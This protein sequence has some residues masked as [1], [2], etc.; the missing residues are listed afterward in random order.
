MPTPWKLTLAYDGT[1]FHGWQV[2]PG[3]PTIQG[4]L[5]DALVRITGEQVLPQGSG[6]TD[7]G[8]HALG[9]VV[10]FSLHSPIPAPNLMRALNRAL[11]SAIRVLAA[12][13]VPPDF[14]ARYSATEKTYQYRIFRAR[15]GA[16]CSPFLARTVYACPWQLD[17]AAM[18][19]AAQAILEE[20]DFTSFAAVDPD[21]A[22]RTRLQIEGNATSL[23]ENIR[24]LY[25]SSW[26]SNADEST[27]EATASLCDFGPLQPDLLRY[28]VRGNGFLHHMVR[29]LV[30]TFL[31]IGRG[32]HQPEAMSAILAARNRALAGPTAPASGLFLL[33][34]QYSDF[35][36]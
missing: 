15:S 35:S 3:L 27:A 12:E 20:H 23:S 31:E 32:R 4:T 26:S 16:I 6:R 33:K 11:P 29:N 2:Q 18:Q 5:A 30:G 25:E 21:L 10:S 36:R 22:T 19:Q 28:T 13:I 1:D 24:T 9:Q 14:H 8:V 17:L 7:A 34:V